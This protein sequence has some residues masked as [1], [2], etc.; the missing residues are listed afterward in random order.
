[1]NRMSM[2]PQHLLAA[3]ALACLALGAHAETGKLK[4]TGGV[5][6]IDGAAGGGISPW[7]LIGTQ[8]AA[9]EWGASAFASQAR[10]QDYKLNVAGAAFAWNNRVEVSYAQQSFDTGPTGVALGLPG[11]TLKQNITG[12]KVRLAGEAILDADTWMPQISI[13]ALNKSLDAGGLK[14]T[15]TTL[16]AKTSGTDV[17]LSATKLFLGPGV[18]VNATLRSTNAN[19]NG[20]LGFGS[21]R[22]GGKRWMPEISIAKLLSPSLA[23]G[24]E[25]RK[26][27]DNLN[28]ILGPGVLA[29]QDWKDIFIAWVP[30]KQLSITAAY[31]DLGQI[32]PPFVAAK[33][34]GWY[35]SAQAAF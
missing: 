32:A 31:V 23:I 1:M 27:P 6:T 33:Q 4:L 25:Y 21:A 9:G 16:G 29:E 14:P 19:Q 8:A 34:T 24:I 17:Y 7:A 12:V 5:S 22:E 2:R 3:S 13:G 18:L 30:H 15:L 20:L 35:L 11:L 10:T 28:R 26:K